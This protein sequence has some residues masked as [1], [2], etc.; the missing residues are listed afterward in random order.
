MVAMGKMSAMR[1]IE[2]KNGVARLQHGRECLHV[3]LRP[4]M[5]LNVRVFGPKKLLSPLPRQF[6]HNVGVLAAAIVALAGIT[7]GILVS[8]DRTHGFEHSFADKILGSDQF[9]AFM[10]T[11]NFVV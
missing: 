5:G 1:Q 4:G 3:G 11:A 7:F 9:Q 10:L 8:E 2:S 6:L